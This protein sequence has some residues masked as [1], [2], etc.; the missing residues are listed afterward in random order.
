VVCFNRGIFE[1]F[2]ES[3]DLAIGPRM[4]KLCKFVYN[5]VFLTYFIKRVGLVKST[6]KCNIPKIG[7]ESL[8]GCLIAQAF[9]GCV[10]HD[11]D[12]AVKVFLR[13]V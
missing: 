13:E 10:I 12:D 8:L 9:S 5:V 4:F 1:G 3:F 6:L 7:V 2:V 11:I